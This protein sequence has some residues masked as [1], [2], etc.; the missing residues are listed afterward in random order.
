MTK[1]KRF[2]ARVNH[3]LELLERRQLLTNNIVLDFTPD[4]IAN[5]YAVGKFADIFATSNVNSTNKYL[6]YNGDAKIN[7]DDANLAA[8]KISSR[9]TRL[10]K[11]FADD[12][13]VDLVIY[14][15]TDLSSTADP[16]AGEVRLAQGLASPTNSTYV[17]Y[18]GN[19]KAS[20]YPTTFRHGSAVKGRF[21]SWNTTPMHSLVKLFSICRPEALNG[22]LS[23]NSNRS[24]SPTKSLLRLRTSWGTCGAW[25]T[26]APSTPHQPSR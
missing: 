14:N 5:E 6:D 15:T 19:L 18:V 10:L 13:A 26:C 4:T 7:L 8:K 12:A 17:V 21:Q 2:R 23:M 1:T 3:Q 22:S 24:T 16:G 25:G 11:P 20:R 9:V